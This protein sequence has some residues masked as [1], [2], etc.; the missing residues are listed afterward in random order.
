M[1]FHQVDIVC[2]K[3]FKAS[4]H[5]GTNRFRRQTRRCSRLW[6]YTIW[7]YPC[8]GT[9]A[10]HLA[11]NNHAVARSTAH[12]GTNICLGQSLSLGSCRHCVHLGG[13]QTI[14]SMI[15]CTGELFVRLFF[16]VLFTIGHGPQA[17]LRYN[18]VTAPEP[19]SFNDALQNLTHKR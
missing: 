5:R 14:D 4:L 12:P 3:T 9:G 11:K 16:R 2:L 13:I 15:P 10:R 17:D 7:R 6:R 8:L 1:Q 18:E 19:T